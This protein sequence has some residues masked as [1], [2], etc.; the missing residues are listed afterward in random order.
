M[1]RLL[2]LV[3][4]FVFLFVVSP[5][6]AASLTLSP[7]S[8]TQTSMA[9]DILVDTAGK[10]TTGVD[11]V[12]TYDKTKLS[13]T[14]VQPG[15]LYDTY[16]QPTIDNTAGRVSVSG[17]V[18]PEKSYNG[19]GKFAQLVFQP[20]G[21]GDAKVEIAYTKGER[22]DSNVADTGG[23]D[24]LTQVNNTTLKVNGKGGSG[25]GGFFQNLLDL[26]IFWD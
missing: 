10:A 7:A 4:P 16:T 1:K 17:L 2:A 9:V 8:P 21:R 18:Q 20:I 23:N 14:N 19:K 5:V 22:N 6:F 26:L 13:L 15:N 24:V 12:V 25:I 3:S 11:L